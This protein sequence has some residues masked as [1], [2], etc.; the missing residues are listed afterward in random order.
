MT[1]SLLM[2]VVLIATGNSV[3]A[4]PQPRLNT[5]GHQIDVDKKRY[6]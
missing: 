5:W 3:V 4:G 2:A 6:G 1:I